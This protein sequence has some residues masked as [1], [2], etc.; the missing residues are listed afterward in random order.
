MYFRK[1]T[2]KRTLSLMVIIRGVTGIFA[3]SREICKTDICA[4]KFANIKRGSLRVL[5]QRLFR[6]QNGKVSPNLSPSQSLCSS[7]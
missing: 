1:Y 7:K 2:E 4:F 5:S 3:N 6:T